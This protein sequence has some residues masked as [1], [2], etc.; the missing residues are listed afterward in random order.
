L[1]RAASSSAPAIFAHLAHAAALIGA[2][3]GQHHGGL[4]VEQALGH[5]HAVVRL[6]RHAL[7]RQP[8]RRD[9]AERVEQF[10]HAARIQ[11]GFGAAARP[12]FD[13]AV[14]LQQLL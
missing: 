5:H 7:L 8:R 4:A 13:E 14:A 11:Q 9:A 12:P 3:D 2:F 10:A 6:G 1:S